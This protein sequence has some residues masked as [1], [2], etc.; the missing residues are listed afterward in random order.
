MPGK[1]AAVE[2]LGGS[3]KNIGNGA[4]VSHG[5]DVPRLIDRRSPTT[6]VRARPTSRRIGKGF[7]FNRGRRES[8]VTPIDF[9]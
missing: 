2:T 8:R 6:A 3:S 7:V 9:A 4:Q 1:P 5:F